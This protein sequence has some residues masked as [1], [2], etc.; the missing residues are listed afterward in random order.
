MALVSLGI[1]ALFLNFHARTLGQREI[2]ILESV[3][4]PIDE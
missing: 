2:D 1:Y 3:R 4:E